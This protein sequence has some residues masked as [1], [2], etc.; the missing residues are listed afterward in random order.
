M[1]GFLSRLRRSRSGATAAEFALVLPVLLLFLLGIIEVGRLMWF[2]NKAEKATQFGVRYAVVTKPVPTGLAGYNF[3]GV[4]GLTQGDLIP[5]TAYGRMTCT[6][7]GCTCDTGTCGWGTAADN[8]AFTKIYDH[9]KLI[10]PELQVANVVVQ[11]SPSGLGY[12]GNPSTT[13]PDVS[14]LVTVGITGLVYTP[15]LYTLFGSTG[16]TL[17]DGLF[18]SSLTME[19]ASGAVSN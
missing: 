12:A 6:S 3:N 4:G 15:M 17:S 11:Y 9:M 5:D 14:P 16:I 7:T 18:Q 10:L 2:W 8:A 1:S 19:D 13:M